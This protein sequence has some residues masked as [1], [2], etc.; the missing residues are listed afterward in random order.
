MS[1]V[2]IFAKNQYSM[3]PALNFYFHVSMRI[4]SKRSLIMSL[5]VFSASCCYSLEVG[6]DGDLQ[7][8]LYREGR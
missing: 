8:A 7:E 1:H 2:V 4:V 5:E 3:A 6:M